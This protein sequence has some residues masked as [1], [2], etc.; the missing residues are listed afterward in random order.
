MV[1]RNAR[2]SDP[3]SIINACL[4]IFNIVN[5]NFNIDNILIIIRCQIEFM[6]VGSLITM[7]SSI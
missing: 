7:K 1:F 4:W 2:F 6:F 5:C 3:S